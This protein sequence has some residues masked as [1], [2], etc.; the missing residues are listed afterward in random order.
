MLSG[1]ILASGFSRRF[2]SDK[3]TYEIF[4]KP[5]VEHV[6]NNCLDS[7]LDE[8]IVVYR[9]NEIFEYLKKY[10]IKLIRNEHA[11]EGMA[12]S[13]RLG[14]KNS[15]SA[16]D[17][18]LI[19]MGDQILFNSNDIDK[20]IDEFES[21]EI[22]IAATYEGKRRTPVI[23]PSSYYD[24]LIMMRGDEGGR[25]ILKDESN[26]RIHLEYERIKSID[27]DRIEDVETV[28]KYLKNK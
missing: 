3:L 28:L 27:I 9:K 8:I 25:S 12:A 2:K 4:D 21:N 22:I 1:I 17:G 14:V 5:L 6:V 20:M 16:S 13:L 7:K 24:Q 19:L 18:Y 23:F 11:E 15:S 10:N 26:K